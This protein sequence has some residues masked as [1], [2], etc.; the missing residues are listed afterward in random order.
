[1]VNIVGWWPGTVV[2]GSGLTV[3][4]PG[5]PVLEPGPKEHGY[6][7]LERLI[8]VE[9]ADIANNSL[10][11]RPEFSGKR[12]KGYKLRAPQAGFSDEY[13]PEQLGDIAEDVLRPIKRSTNSWRPCQF[14]GKNHRE[15]FALDRVSGGDFTGHT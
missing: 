1:M 7:R 2:G 5:R 3:P 6:R 14:C 13:R 4:S 9:L 10:H 8:Q 15:I 12:H 11:L